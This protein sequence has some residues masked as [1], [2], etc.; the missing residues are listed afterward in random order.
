ML[1]AWDLDSKSGTPWWRGTPFPHPAPIPEDSDLGHRGH[2]RMSLSWFFESTL[3]HF[4]FKNG[5]G[6]NLRTT[7]TV[8]LG[9][10]LLTHT[11]EAGEK[12]CALLH[13]HS[14]K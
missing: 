4:L 1:Q 13:P 9:P 2:C 7:S 5:A 14:Q 10:I 11:P 12:L 3:V 8:P 6:S